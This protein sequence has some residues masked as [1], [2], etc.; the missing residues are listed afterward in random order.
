[1]QLNEDEIKKLKERV[2]DY[3]KKGIFSKG[4]SKFVD[5]F[6]LNSKNSL[7]SAKLLFEASTNEEVKK[8][9]GVAEFNG[10]LW[11]INASY[12]S[13]FY[14]ARALLESKG[15]KIKRGESSIHLLT[16][17][18]FIYHFYLTGALKKKIIEDFGESM[19]E[20]SQSL[21]D[22]RAKEIIEDYSNEKYKR[23]LYTYEMGINALRNKAQTSLERAKRFS[24][25]L[26]K[27]LGL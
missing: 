14:L 25:D 7:E 15:I 12:Y 10:F 9:L 24:D 2:A 5:F 21:G 16:L 26:R 18:A 6:I 17:D 8:D 23:G 3:L 13:M 27:I 19:D 11:V 1:M 20:S 22:Q 4:D